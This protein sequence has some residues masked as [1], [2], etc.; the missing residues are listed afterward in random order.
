M[1]EK[2]YL[3]LIGINFSVSEEEKGLDVNK[4]FEELIF[5]SM[6]SIVSD[7][8][9]AGLLYSWLVKHS[10]L[11]DEKK[12]YHFFSNNPTYYCFMSG[13]ILKTKNISRFKFFLENTPKNPDNS[14]IPYKSKRHV[15]WGFEKPD[16][17]ILSQG[18]TITTITLD[19][20]KKLRPRKWI[21]AQ[22]QLKSKF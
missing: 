18:I 9:F 2:L 13:L 6:N 21:E 19:D 15:E 4:S 10:D 8:K 12:L 14:L 3:A 5:L 16:P 7:L 20:D 1:R 17:E 11:L 22:F